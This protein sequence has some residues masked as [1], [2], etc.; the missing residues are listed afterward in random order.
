MVMVGK[1]S[2]G[3]GRRLAAGLQYPKDQSSSYDNQ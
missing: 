2:P 1:G 3:V